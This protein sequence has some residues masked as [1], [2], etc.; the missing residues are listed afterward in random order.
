[1]AH[2]ILRFAPVVLA[3]LCAG[4]ASVS[5][6]DLAFSSVQ[7]V[8]HHD[9]PE[10]P[11]PGDMRWILAR[12]TGNAALLAVPEAAE[13]AMIGSGDA[14]SVERPHEL[15][16]KARFTSDVDLSKI[17]FRDNLDARIFFCHRPDA[18]TLLDL[19]R[20]YSHGYAVVPGIY[21]EPVR[22][23]EEKAGRRFVYYIFFRVSRDERGRHSKPPVESFDL[24]QNPED[25]CFKLVGG[26][27]RAF[28]Y[29]SNVV[30]VPKDSIAAAL[31]DHPVQTG[32]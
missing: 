22:E 24:R 12:M 31:R 1:M 17:D 28:G 23:A 3:L 27:H 7:V 29:S 14:K 11:I 2:R 4:C 16:V 9:Q 15:L 19:P 5:I 32:H 18:Y 25:V 20:V 6:H 10:L 13:L 21:V 30:L 26:A 8:D